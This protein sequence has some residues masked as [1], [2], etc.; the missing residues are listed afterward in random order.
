MVDRS[1]SGHPGASERGAMAVCRGR[2]AAIVAGWPDLYRARRLGYGPFV[3]L[4]HGAGQSY[5][6]DRHSAGS[7]SYAGARDHDDVAVFVVP[8]PDPAKRWAERYPEARVVQS[9]NMKPLPAREGEPGRVVAVTFHWPCAIIPEAGTAWRHYSRAVIALAERTPLLGHWH[10]RWGDHL[11]RW[12]EDNGI[13]P[14]VSLDEVA[15]RSDLLVADNTSAIFEYADTGRPVLLL[16]SPR[17]RRHVQHGLRFWDASHVGIQVDDPERLWEGVR[18]AL[19]DPPGMRWARRQALSMV[20][21][22]GGTRAVVEAIEA[23]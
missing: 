10:P 6:G 12:Y 1:V 7:H 11:R 4:Q 22:P 23:M 5:N 20:Y 13:E 2:G 21:A 16:N 15:R 9:G 18:M 14:V 3:L 8:G 17:Y 19:A